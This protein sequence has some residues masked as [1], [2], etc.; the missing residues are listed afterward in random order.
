MLRR[1]KFLVA[2][3]I[4]PGLADELQAQRDLACLPQTQVEAHQLAKLNRLLDRWRR[5]DF[6]ARLLREHGAP[7]GPLES[8]DRL[9]LLPV[10]SKDFLRDNLERMAALPSAGRRFSTS[11]ST[12]QTVRFYRSPNMAAARTAATLLAWE[13][14]GMDYLTDRRFM[15]WDYSRLARSRLQRLD[16]ALRR[17]VLNGRLACPYGMDDE[18]AEMILRRI[19]RFRPKVIT[20]FASYLYSLAVGGRRRGIQPFRPGFLLSSGE[21]LL[22]E[23]R[24]LLEGCFR[25]PVYDRYG[26]S[27]AD[28]I[29][30]QCLEKDCLHIPPTRHYLETDADGELLVTDLDNFATPLIRYAIGDTGQVR[31]SDCPCGRTGQVIGPALGRVYDRILTPSGRLLPGNFWSGLLRLRPGVEQYQLV[32]AE[33]ARVEIRI[34]A[35]AEYRDAHADFY[36]DE[37]RRL[38]GDELD[39]AVARMDRIEPGPS[40][41]H[42]FVIRLAPGRDEQGG[43]PE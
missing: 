41:K 32:Q 22:P 34:V 42:R 12:G 23:Y 29:G 17:W 5:I 4:R 21:R 1:V 16:V 20:G 6:Y 19:A 8:L 15:V 26:A 37:V 27:E 28:L 38:V 13:M 10:V 39:V 36:R 14:V 43:R 25:A 40:G 33:P 24:A 7:A 30:Q 9:R 11:G 2:R 35:N 18:Q 3:M 31:R